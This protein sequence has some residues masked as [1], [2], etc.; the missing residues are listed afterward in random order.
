V[1]SVLFLGCG[2]F[3]LAVE[4]P[5]TATPRPTAAVTLPVP[6]PTAAPPPLATLDP[7]TLEIETATPVEES[8]LPP[9]PPAQADLPAWL[10]QAWALGADPAGLRPGLERAGW[11][12]PD[13]SPQVRPP[14]TPEAS[15]WHVIDLDGEDAPEWVV[16]IFTGQTD[17]GGPSGRMWVINGSGL[18]FEYIVDDERF[19]AAPIGILSADL[20]GDGLPEIVS[21]SRVCGVSTCFGAYRVLSAH[22]G[23][24]QNVTRGVGVLFE[25]MRCLSQVD[26]SAPVLPEI[27]ISSPGPQIA[28]ATGDGLLDFVLTG[29][30]IASA[31]AGD[32]QPCITV[33][34]WDGQAIALAG[35]RR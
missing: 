35:I 5:G 3:E 30:A 21:E 18:A 7:L 14:W 33:W 27:F 16:T 31:A 15:L 2:T 32:P 29:G 25:D 17:W 19:F 1:L 11:M 34:A 23:G 10:S 12:V 26:A 8:A 13:E 4:L 9:R 28:E 6:V 20:T 24:I 22:P